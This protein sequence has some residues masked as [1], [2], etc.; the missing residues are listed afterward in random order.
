MR[1]GN[2]YAYADRN[3]WVGKV[4]R[5]ELNVPCGSCPCVHP[6]RDGR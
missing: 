6:N 2:A 4:G 3:G 5:I 1:D